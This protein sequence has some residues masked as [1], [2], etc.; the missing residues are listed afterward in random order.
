[1]A[2]EHQWLN[3]PARFPGGTIER[4]PPSVGDVLAGGRIP[5]EFFHYF[6]SDGAAEQISSPDGRHLTR[7]GFTR[8]GDYVA[9]DDD[10]LTVLQLRPV[11]LAVS[12]V[13][14][15]TLESFAEFLAICEDEYPYYTDD[16]S[17]FEACEA[18]ADNL[19]SV[20]MRIDARAL[21]PGTYWSDFLA[22]VANGDYAEVV[23][24]D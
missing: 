21:D 9:V 5:A 7:I 8:S 14:N 19:R 3:G 12:S 18:A 10:N 23:D 2:L 16:D 24:D 20:L 17:G 1:M 22:D 4:L 13:I 11:D 15:T 6:R